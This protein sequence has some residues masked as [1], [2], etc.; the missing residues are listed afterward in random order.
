MFYLT[1]LIDSLCPFF[2]SNFFRKI[3]LATLE[4]RSNDSVTKFGKFSSLQQLLRV[5]EIRIFI[6]KI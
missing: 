1:P 3:C 2:N 4:V 5:E 6:H